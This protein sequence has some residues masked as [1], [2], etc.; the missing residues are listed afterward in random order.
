MRKST[1]KVLFGLS[2]VFM[3]LLSLTFLAMPA[4]NRLSL[5]G[6]ARL[7]RLS[8]VW[9][10]ATLILGYALFLLVHRAR[11]QSLR[12]GQE[13]LPKGKPGII[14]FF[15]NPWAFFADIALG[16]GIIL[17]VVFLWVDASGYPVFALLS[18]T[19]FA[20]QMHCVLNGENFR[21]IN[22][23][24]NTASDHRGKSLEG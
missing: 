12:A 1:Q 18:V 16:V 2:A 17:F 24:L 3:L 4:A 5:E 23:A 20:F 9:F 6:N 8:G 7:L 21:Y 15:A 13:E 19:V 11:K 10:W 22:A 14:R